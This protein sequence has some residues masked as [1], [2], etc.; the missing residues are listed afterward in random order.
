[1]SLADDGAGL[2]IRQ[3]RDE[4]DEYRRMVIWRNRPHVRDW[5]DP[6]DPPFTLSTATAQYRPGTR[7]EA[8][9]TSCVIVLD[10][11]P[12]GYIQFYDWSKDAASAAEIGFVIQPGW[13]GLDIFIGEPDA[14]GQGIGTRALKL[15][16]RYLAEKHHATAVALTVDVDNA[17]AIHAYEKAGFEKRSRV[18]DTDVRNGVRVEAWLMVCSI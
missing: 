11:R 13:W 14:V 10:G 16:S 3:M 2:T 8:E 17:V 5:W 7:P 6:D 4:T 1:M 9:A 12:V 18:L 15:L